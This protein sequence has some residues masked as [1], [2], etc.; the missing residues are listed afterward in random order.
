MLHYHEF[1]HDART[2][3]RAGSRLPA[4][5]QPYLAAGSAPPLVRPYLLG[6]LTYEASPCGRTNLRQGPLHRNPQHPTLTQ[7]LV[8]ARTVTGLRCH[9]TVV[10]PGEYWA[11][12]AAVGSSER[13]NDGLVSA[14]YQGV[15]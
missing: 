14:S 4:H 2:R 8:S 7:Q 15:E 11:V 1:W 9:R 3:D 5:I 10:G 12:C 13:R 6:Q